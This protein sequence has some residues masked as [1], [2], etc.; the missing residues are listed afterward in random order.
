[1][2]KRKRVKGK[3]GRAGEEDVEEG[4]VDEAEEA[5]E[6]SVVLSNDRTCAAQLTPPPPTPP[7]PASPSLTLPSIL[8]IPKMSCSVGKLTLASTTLCKHRDPAL[9]VLG[10]LASTMNDF[11]NP[12]LKERWRQQTSMAGSRTLIREGCIRLLNRMASKLQSEL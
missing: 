2:G 3:G 1:V 6:R 11:A 4:E 12:R 9:P 8:P 5:G 10:T 7:P